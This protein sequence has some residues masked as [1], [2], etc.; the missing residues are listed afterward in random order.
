MQIRLNPVMFRS[1]IQGTAHTKAI[2]ASF[3]P[4]G[5]DTVHFG[6]GADISR[7]FRY[8]PDEEKVIALFHPGLGLQIG[9]IERILPYLPKTI[10]AKVCLELLKPGMADEKV[11]VALAEHLGQVRGQYNIDGIIRVMT[12]PDQPFEVRL[13]TAS[14]ANLIRDPDFYLQTVRLYYDLQPQKVWFGPEERSVFFASKS[15]PQYVTLAQMSEILDYLVYDEKVQT[16]EK[17]QLAAVK[18]IAGLLPAY[19]DKFYHYASALAA[20]PEKSVQLAVVNEL[21]CYK[22][23]AE[24][25][26][27]SL[28]MVDDLIVSLATSTSVSNDVHEA[29][30]LE[31]DNL[32]SQARLEQALRQITSA[33]P[34]NVISSLVRFIP[35]VKHKGTLQHLIGLLEPAKLTS[36]AERHYASIAVTIPDRSLRLKVIRQLANSTTKAACDIL[37]NSIIHRRDDPD[38]P[39]MLAI[40]Q[41]KDGA[42]SPQMQQSLAAKLSHLA[43]NIPDRPAQGQFLVVI[44]NKLQQSPAD[45]AALEAELRELQLSVPEETETDRDRAVQ[46]GFL[47]DFALRKL[48]ELVENKSSDDKARAIAVKT[49]LS[50]LDT[51]YDDTREV[52]YAFVEHCLNDPSPEV[53]KLIPDSLKT[54]Q[55]NA[56]DSPQCKRIV[57]RLLADKAEP[58]ARESLD[59][60]W[61]FFPEEELF[62]AELHRIFVNDQEILPVIRQKAFGWL[63]HRVWSRENKQANS[64]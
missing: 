13:K 10:A 2:R 15:R 62:E 50:N 5:A 56:I 11:K 38:Q 18:E 3:P 26:P 41:G 64:V 34:K 24:D 22:S 35:M 44:F 51:Q 55:L 61:H 7:A 20:H 48:Q 46:R 33:E 40:L 30:L 29:A 12:A 54:K 25:D 59:K 8:T 53:R 42:V 23:A 17:H 39:A 63:V 27:Q 57:T 16:A 45:I 4:L 14:K 43:P 47:K 19:P 9:S 52:Y 32:S 37:A 21:S 58:V 28:Q 6:Q 31:L 1:H 49:I 60:L 36:E